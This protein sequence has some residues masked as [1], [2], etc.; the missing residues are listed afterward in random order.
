MVTD[1]D[2]WKQL[3]GIVFYFLLSIYTGTPCAWIGLY[4]FLALLYNVLVESS[5]RIPYLKIHCSISFS[6]IQ[7]YIILAWEPSLAEV[8]HSN[9]RRLPALGR[10]YRETKFLQVKNIL[11]VNSISQSKFEANR[12]VKGFMSY[13]RTNRKTD[14]TTLYIDKTLSKLTNLY[15]DNLFINL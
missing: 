7:S 2:F 13:D 12:S 10:F 14:I 3:L 15:P 6:F 8:T 9:S 4:I 1:L 11:V 5:S